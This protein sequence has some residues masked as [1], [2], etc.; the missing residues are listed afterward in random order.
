MTIKETR[1]LYYDDAMGYCIEHKAWEAIAAMDF[2]ED[3]DE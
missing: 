3:Y 2:A 1:G